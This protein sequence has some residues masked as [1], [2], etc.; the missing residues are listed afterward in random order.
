MLSILKRVA[1]VVVGVLALVGGAGPAASAVTVHGTE[2]RSDRDGLVV[3][4]GFEQPAGATATPLGW[5]ASSWQPTA[6]LTWSDS[7][8]HRGKHSVR[9][10]APQPDDASWSQTIPVQ[11]HTLYQ[12][13]GWI[14]TE[15]VAHTA[16]LVDA[17]ANLSF[18][19]TWDH[20]PGV[21]GTTGWTKVWVTVNSGDRTELT[22]A[23]RLGY[24]AGSTIGTA[25]FDDLRL[26]RLTPAARA[27]NW[28]VLVLVY[29]SL[30][31]TFPAA[32]G[33]T[34]RVVANPTRE[35]QQRAARAARAFFTTDVPALDSGFM[36][37]QVTVRFPARALTELDPYGE[38][39]WPSPANTAP[40]RD[41]AFDAVLVIWPATGTNVATGQSEWI[42]SAAGLTPDMGTGQAYV[43]M[44]IDAA[45]NY[46]HRNV[47]KHEFGHAVVSYFGALGVT[48]TPAVDNHGPGQYVHC[49]TG[50]EYVLA[51]E[52]LRDPIPNSIYNNTSGF[53]HDYYS[54][55][56][57]LA[58]DPDRCL[59]IDRQ[60][61]RYGGPSRL[62]GSSS[63]GSHS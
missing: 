42:G 14:R 24:W 21:F 13:S 56:T 57:A 15:G 52:T 45:V 7:P 8:A 22:V 20:S 50:A 62:A 10:E 16:E 1:F 5:T 49:G 36:R 26:E 28:R 19:G 4:G 60:A 38:G 44:I 61:W 51:D 12:L 58:G 35:D 18:A 31:F 47:F 48:P 32:D 30:D 6:V 17:G 54:G 25:W 43:S 59:G 39:W 37:P 3:N 53:T 2:V 27:P 55:A 11:P 46:G 41:P 63:T 9:I 40:E 33:T 29:R 23:A 34:H